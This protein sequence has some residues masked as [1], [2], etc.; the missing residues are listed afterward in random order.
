MQKRLSFFDFWAMFAL[1]APNP[2]S[3][4]YAKIMYAILYK[5]KEDMPL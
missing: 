4:E 2:F 5:V 1:I 3:L